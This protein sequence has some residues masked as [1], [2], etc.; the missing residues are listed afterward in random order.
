MKSSGILPPRPMCTSCQPLADSRALEVHVQ[1]ICGRL[2]AELSVLL[3]GHREWI[4]MEAEEICRRAAGSSPLFRYDIRFA[5]GG[6]ACHEYY[7]RY[8]QDN[9]G[10]G[11][12][13]EKA[14]QALRR[15]FGSA[16]NFFYVFRRE[17][18]RMQTGGFLWLCAEVRG[19]KRHMHLFPTEGYRLP[20]VGLR[21]IFALD[22]WEHA[23]L[24]TFGTDRRSYADA[25]LRQLDWEAVGEEMD[26]LEV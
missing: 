4:G 16:D 23:Y 14:A 8:L 17:A 2:A 5:A 26:R 21:P 7:F 11:V 9:G 24:P 18:Q 13:G 22:L 6:L 19:R 3:D 25:F 20:P 1:V 12:P 15:S 10:T